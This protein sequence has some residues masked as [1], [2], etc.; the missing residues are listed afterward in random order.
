MDIINRFDDDPS[1]LRWGQFDNIGF[2][3]LVTRIL[4][5]LYLEPALL[6]DYYP[7]RLNMFSGGFTIDGKIKN[8]HQEADK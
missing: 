7:K 6:L 8:T 4:K 2:P 5:D 1:I 3:F